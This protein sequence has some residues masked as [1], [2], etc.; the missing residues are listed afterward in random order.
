VS[1]QDGPEDEDG[2]DIVFELPPETKRH[3]DRAIES[4]RAFLRK[5]VE[6]SNQGWLRRYAEAMRPAQEMIAQVAKTV[7]VSALQA[8]LSAVA[9]ASHVNLPVLEAIRASV[10]RAFAGIDFEA[11]NKALRRSFPPN[12]R[13]LGQR[14]DS[15]RLFD[16]T[17]AGF[18]TVWVPRADVLAELIT[19]ADDDLADVYAKHQVEILEDCTAA[20]A[21]SD[22]TELEELVELLAEAVETAQSGRL[23]SAQALAASIFDTAL[24]HTIK[25]TKITGYYKRVKNEIMDRYD[26]TLSELRWG[27]AHVPAVVVLEMFN[28]P[29]GDPIPTGYN[30]HA[31]AHAAGRIQYTPANAIIAITLA[32]SIVREAQEQIN[33]AAAAASV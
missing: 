11:L 13:Q 27:L 7:D 5:A 22:A 8:Q 9:A 23:R 4:Q 20:L 33:E 16:I 26:S 32:T 17:E 25:P 10:D 19:T 3:L 1:D 30:R 31:S 21:E 2:D 14:L 24:R 29:A 28:A 12:W 15:D 18:P 6:P